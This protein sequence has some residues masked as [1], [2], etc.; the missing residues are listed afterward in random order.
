[1]VSVMVILDKSLP[2]IDII[3]K[4]TAGSFVPLRP[5]PEGYR[6]AMYAAGD[7]RDWA[8]IETSVAEFDSETQA[9][10]Y[11]SK[12]F[13]PHPNELPRRCTFIETDGGEKVATATAWFGENFGARVPLVHWVAVTPGH[14]GKGLGKPLVSNLINLMRELEGDTDFYLHTQTWSHKALFIYEWAGFR[15][16]S[17]T[18]ALGCA[19]RDY[20]RAVEIIN[21]LRGCKA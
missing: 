15:M 18:G 6:F 9:L 19:N 12:E 7:E 8:R 1:M 13:L 20:D 5:L 3:M 16:V 14:Q 4:R 11:F 17:E 2:Y 10:E 21:G